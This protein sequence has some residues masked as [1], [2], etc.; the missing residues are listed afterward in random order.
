MAFTLREYLDFPMGKGS[1]VVNLSQIKSEYRNELGRYESDSTFNKQIRIK[2]YMKGSRF[3][4]IHFAFPSK[5]VDIEYDVVFEF[6]LR[7]Y[8]A[9]PDRLDNLNFRVFSNCPSFTYT[10]AFVFDVQE[11]LIPWLKGRF[12]KE[13]FTKKPNVRNPYHIQGVERSIYLCGL[14]ILTGGRNN[15]KYLMNTA[16]KLDN[17]VFLENQI[18]K[19]DD[20]MTR[21][22]YLKKRQSV[23]E[24]EEKKKSDT[25]GPP[26]NR[27]PKSST[28]VKQVDHSKNA[29][30]TKKTQKTKKTKKI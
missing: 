16:T 4:I 18:K 28:S 1:S 2:S 19:Q 11:K 10:Y 27:F 3:L 15:V 21:Y 8:D 14:Y 30:S 25:S 17:P 5:S 9:I 26:I 7:T 29:A 24:K 23:E 13:V 6:D 22:N 12:D 20:I